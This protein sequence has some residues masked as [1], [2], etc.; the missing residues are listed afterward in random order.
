VSIVVPVRDGWESTLRCLTALAIHSGGV[1]R[2]TIVVDNGSTDDT[3]VA[4]PLLEGIRVIRNEED[5]GFAR[6]CNQAASAALGDAIVFLDRSAE[7][8]PGWL[9]QLAGVFAGEPVA[10]VCPSDESGLSGAFLAVRAG[11]FRDAGGLDEGRPDAADSLLAGFLEAGRR[12]GV[13]DGLAM[14]FGALPPPPSGAAAE[15]QVP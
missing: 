9:R 8:G 1:R 6:A 11:F 14:T 4:L 13:V 12:I 10:A 15:A 3:R 5:A 2:E 7:V